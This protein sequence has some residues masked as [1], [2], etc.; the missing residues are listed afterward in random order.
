MD[1]PAERL[2]ALADPDRWRI[3]ALLAER[4]RSVGVVAQLAGLRQPQASKHLQ[5][6]ERA[7][8]VVSQ[9]SGQRRIYALE[10]EPLRELATLI[11]GLAETVEQNRGDRE[12]F[13]KYF[14]S[15]AAEILAADRERWADD[16]VFTFRRVLAAPRDRVW[17]H[18]TDP[19][20]A[21]VWWSPRDLA[22]SELV[23]EPRPGGRVILEYRDADDGAGTDGIVG[24][25]E[26]VVDVAVGPERLAFRLSPQLPDG[27]VAFTGHYALTLREQGA[28]ST[29]LDVRLRIADSAIASAEFI[30]GIE[31][32]WSQCL[33]QLVD[34]VAVSGTITPSKE[35]E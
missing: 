10:T 22:V 5:R 29:A 25:A 34:A 20:L 27:G 14:M 1:P 17:R 30:A 18:L 9:R 26:G 4:P 7:G 24:R 3:V 11:G 19:D 35:K 15:R 21:A 16:R 13:D 8:L 6:L 23:L 33:D 12:T 31:I 28:E 32:G 2:A